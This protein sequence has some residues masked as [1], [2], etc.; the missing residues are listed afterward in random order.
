MEAEQDVS[1][2]LKALSKK[3][4]R[5]RGEL[6]DAQDQAMSAAAPRAGADWGGLIPMGRHNDTRAQRR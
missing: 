2:K 3:A 4:Q 5:L 6:R 1:N